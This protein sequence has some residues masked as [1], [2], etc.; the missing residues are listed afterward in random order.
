M[1]SENE[2]KLVFHYFS[3]PVF[4]QRSRNLLMILLAAPIGNEKKKKKI[5]FTQFSLMQSAK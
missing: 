2:S 1:V 4:T 5:I 3:F